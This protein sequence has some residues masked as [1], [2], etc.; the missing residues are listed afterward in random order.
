MKY[1]IRHYLRDD[2]YSWAVF[3]CKDIEGTLTCDI[4]KKGIPQVSG[5]TYNQAM[6]ICNKLNVDAFQKERGKYAQISKM[7]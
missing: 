7:V 6:N 5:L 4:I 2:A 3:L 1:D